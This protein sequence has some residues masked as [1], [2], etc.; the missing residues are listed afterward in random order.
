MAQAI[1]ISEKVIEAVNSLQDRLYAKHWG[2]HSRA[3][4]IYS[5]VHSIHSLEEI[6]Q[7]LDEAKTQFGKEGKN[8][9]GL[10][11]HIKELENLIT[12]LDRNNKLEQTRV[13]TAREKGIELLAD[14]LTNPDLYSSLEQKV[15]AF[16]L[17]TRFLV[18][19]LSILE[20][21]EFG[22]GTTL[23]KSPKKVLDLLEEKE[24]EFQALK[25]KYEE[26]RHSSHLARLEENTSHDLEKDINILARK[27]EGEQRM[28][29]LSLDSYRKITEQFQQSYIF[30]REKYR[31]IEEASSQLAA[32]T[33]DLTTILKKE[34]DYA[35]RIVLDIENETLKLRNNYSK[36][37]LS[38]E[39]E[40]TRARAEAEVESRK[41]L[42]SITSKLD[43]KDELIKN[44]KEIILSKEKLIQKLEQSPQK[45][46]KKN[47][48]A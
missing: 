33:I 15:L 32:K 7:L 31:S 24:N 41:K 39:E 47:S 38:L 46:N 13:Q 22:E 11:E 27:M 30:M 43:E 4:F 6:K 35:K 36:Q 23:G 8:V 37:I 28:L 10:P 2:E 44:L 14:D 45:E 25:K 12:V 16:V 18:E 48:R 9:S 42:H 40:K 19:R 20:R 29:E 1:I 21:K 5:L 3:S 34:R 17:K 26:I